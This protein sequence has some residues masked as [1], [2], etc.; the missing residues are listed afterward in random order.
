MPDGVVEWIANWA[1]TPSTRPDAA[2]NARTGKKK[3][4]QLQKRP[5][6]FFLK[7]EVFVR[8]GWARYLHRW[9]MPSW[10]MWDCVKS[11]SPR[12]EAPPCWETLQSYLPSCLPL[13]RRPSPSTLRFLLSECV[14]IVPHYHFSTHSSLLHNPTF[15]PFI[16]YGKCVWCFY[17]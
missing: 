11:G 1:T 15:I 12:R 4:Q 9:W 7:M 3:K 10:L 13:R 16:H 6:C 5:A 17:F 2:E 14:P 8:R